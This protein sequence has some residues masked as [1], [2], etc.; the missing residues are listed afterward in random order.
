M[1]VDP[2]VFNDKL[3]IDKN[4]ID[5]DD[6]TKKFG[7][8]VKNL[9]GGLMNNMD[10]NFKETRKVPISRLEKENAKILKR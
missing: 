7:E 2:E 4:A 10:S 5:M 3:L 8:D 9:L 1:L 6:Y